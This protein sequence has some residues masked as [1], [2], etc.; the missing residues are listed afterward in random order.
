MTGYAVAWPGDRDA[1]GHPVWYG[2]GKLAADL[3]LPKLLQ[4]WQPALP[5]ILGHAP[6]RRGRS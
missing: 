4:R 1:A 5:R 3:S 6:S 2:G